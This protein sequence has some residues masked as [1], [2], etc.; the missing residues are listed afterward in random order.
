M[1]ALSFCL[2]V[3]LAVGALGAAVKEAEAEDQPP[4]IMSALQSIMSQTEAQAGDAADAGEGDLGESGDVGE[5]G[6]LGESGDVDESSE[7]IEGKR[8]EEMQPE[9][10]ES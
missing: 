1:K 10:E 4:S 2:L 5:S 7:H 9:K 6:D 3:A 8:M